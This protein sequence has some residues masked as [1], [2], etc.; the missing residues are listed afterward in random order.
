VGFLSP[1]RGWFVFCIV[2]A[3]YAAG[4]IL[5]PLR[6]WNARRAFELRKSQNPHPNVAKYAPLGWGTRADS[7]FS[8]HVAIQ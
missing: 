8:F 2:P 4:F 3:A 5:A 6:G 1:L 7:S